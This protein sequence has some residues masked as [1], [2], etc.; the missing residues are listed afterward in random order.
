MLSFIN[1]YGQELDYQGDGRYSFWGLFGA[2]TGMLVGGLLCSLCIIAGGV[3]GG[4]LGS[5]GGKY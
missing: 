2:I 1:S 4:V 5:T 3:L